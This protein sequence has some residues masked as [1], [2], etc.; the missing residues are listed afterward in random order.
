MKSIRLDKLIHKVG[1]P[2]DFIKIDQEK[3]IGCRKCVKVCPVNLWYIEKGKA[4]I[5][6][7]Y[8]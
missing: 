4:K 1:D 8:K 2:E 5:R 6:D 7:N 3:C